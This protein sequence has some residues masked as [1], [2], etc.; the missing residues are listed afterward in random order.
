MNAEDRKRV[1]ITVRGDVQGV[2][3]RWFAERAAREHG[4]V[5]WVMNHSD[6]SVQVEAE[7]LAQDIERF[8]QKIRIGPRSGR[9]DDVKI[10][11]LPILGDKIF[12]IR[13]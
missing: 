7:G 10:I 9:V 4:V 6:G 1:R 5:G 8:M 11:P 2:G 12:S 3:F 13:Y